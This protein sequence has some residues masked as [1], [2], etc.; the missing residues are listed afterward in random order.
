MMTQDAHMMRPR[1]GGLTVLSAALLITVLSAALLTMPAGAVVNPV[2][3]RIPKDD[4]EN[5]E[6][7]KVKKVCLASGR[8]QYQFEV[9]Y[10]GSRRWLTISPGTGNQLG[11]G[12]TT[13]AFQYES[14]VWT[15]DDGDDTDD[16]DD[17]ADDTDDAYFKVGDSDRSDP[18]PI[19]NFYAVCRRTATP[20]DSATQ[21]AMD[22]STAWQEVIDATSGKPGARYGTLVAAWNRWHRDHCVPGGTVDCGARYPTFAET[23]ALNPGIRLST[24]ELCPG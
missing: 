14:G 9:G 24:G 8:H 20:L 1:R 12:L 6:I 3:P 18:A 22:S 15:R 5:P 2:N 23:C 21:A 11:W 7:P 17:D 10:A 4:H 19:A 16:N 13:D